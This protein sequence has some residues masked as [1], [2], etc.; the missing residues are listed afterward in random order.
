MTIN[1]PKKRGGPHYTKEGILKTI[2]KPSP[3]P[4]VKLGISIPSSL[5][6]RVR[7]HCAK[8]S[9][10]VSRFISGLALDCLD[11]LDKK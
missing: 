5:E 11:C 1:T 4:A 8:N 10:K 3:D 6:R 7:A 2:R 9:I